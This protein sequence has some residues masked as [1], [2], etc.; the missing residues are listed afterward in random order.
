[1]YTVT[2]GSE[3]KLHSLTISVAVTPWQLLL[4][5]GEG[6]GESEARAG[7]RKSACG[8]GQAGATQL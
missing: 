4:C 3:L 5:I 6:G 2:A 7:G 8:R 1:M